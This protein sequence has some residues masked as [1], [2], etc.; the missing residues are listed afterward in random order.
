MEGRSADGKIGWKVIELTGRV[1]G[2]YCRS[3]SRK[4]GWKI[5]LPTGR[6]VGRYS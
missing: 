6:L 1:V 5:D 3:A 2:R 4:T